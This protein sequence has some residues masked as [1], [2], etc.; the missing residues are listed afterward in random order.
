MMEEEGERKIL[1]NETNIN[2]GSDIDWKYV[3]NGK[4]LPKFEGVA[5]LQGNSGNSGYHIS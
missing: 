1:Q 2:Q 5:K 3:P 4:V